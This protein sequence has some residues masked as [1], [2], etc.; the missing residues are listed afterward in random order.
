MRNGI[1]AAV[2]RVLGVVA[3]LLVFGLGLKLLAA[4][5]SPVLPPELLHILSGG[6]DLLFSLVG[7]AWP[8]IGAIFILAVLGLVVLGRRR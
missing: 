7:G 3:G 1:G 4:L 8:A 6:W 2:G 5:L